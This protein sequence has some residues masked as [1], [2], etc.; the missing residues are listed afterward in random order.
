MCPREVAD[1]ESKLAKSL[2]KTNRKV[3]SLLDGLIKDVE[4][5][6]ES[7][8]KTNQKLDA[9]LARL[10]DSKEDQQNAKQC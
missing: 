6:R 8:E 4:K 1:L 5:N 2:E 3:Y 10:T 7:L 9:L